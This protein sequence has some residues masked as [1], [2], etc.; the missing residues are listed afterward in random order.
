MKSKNS[1]F[2]HLLVNGIIFLC[3]YVLSYV[4][5]DI[6]L[7]AWSHHTYFLLLN[8]ALILVLCLSKTYAVAYAM[9]FG[10]MIGILLGY[11]LGNSI[12]TTSMA[13]ITSDMNNQQIQKLSY[14]YGPM[15]WVWCV[16]ICIILTSIYVSKRRKK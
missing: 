12:R 5:K 7:F 10:N 6:P 1:V 16:I 2:R 11:F 14:N 3:I 9:T 15:I 13:K 8:G 4:L